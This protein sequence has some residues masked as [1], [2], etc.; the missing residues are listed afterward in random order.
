MHGKN[1]QYKI[2]L[3]FNILCKHNQANTTQGQRNFVFKTEISK[4]KQ[5]MAAILF[6][7]Y[8]VEAMI[9]AS[10]WLLTFQSRIILIDTTEHR[11]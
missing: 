11:W 5:N 9:F 3:K 2:I 4:Y 8:I 1:V 10:T 7:L 6:T